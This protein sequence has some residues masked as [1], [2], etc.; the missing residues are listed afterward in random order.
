MNDFNAMIQRRSFL[1]QVGMCVGLG[2]VPIAGCAAD[3]PEKWSAVDARV[4]KA[5]DEGQCPGAVLAV[6]SKGQVAHSYVYGRR[7]LVPEI[8]PMLWQTVFDMASL[9]KPLI[10]ALAIMQYVER[11]TIGIDEL[12][13]HYL[14][15]FGSMGKESITIRLLLT[16]YSGLPP[17]VPLKAPWSGKEEAVRLVMNSPLVA[18]PGERFLYSDINYITLGLIIEKLSGQSLAVYAHENILSPMGL[19]H[20]QFLPPVSERAVIAPTQFDDEGHL[21]Q[22]VVHDPTSRRMG[23]VAGHAGFFST[24]DDVCLYAQELLNRLKG[25]ESRFPLKQETLASMVVPEQ[26][27]GKTDLRGFGWDLHTSFSTPRGELFSSQSFGHTGFT[28]TSLWID[29]VSEAYVVLLT[30]RVHPYGGHSVVSLRHDVA[31]LVAQA[32]AS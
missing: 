19:K 17:D 14:P 24:A 30:N 21:L 11:G 13:T 32:L 29:P 16:H 3:R 10:T 5:V 2:V 15:E 4:R 8:Q 18:K 1:T 27:Q 25:R 7:A 22:G 23:G 20:S 9:T 31:T 28:G 12:V 26:P 6:G